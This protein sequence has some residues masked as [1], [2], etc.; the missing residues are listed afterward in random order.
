MPIVEYSDKDLLRDKLVEPAW[1]RVLIETIG[2]WTASSDQKSQNMVVEGTVLFNADNGSKEYAGVPIGG[3]GSWSFNS[4]AMGF[5]L[6]LTK[7]VARQLGIEP[8]Q[9]TPKMRFE[10]KH[11]E[12]KQ[13]D[14]FIVH[15]TY[16]GR[17][18]NKVDHQYREPRSLG[19]FV[20]PE[21]TT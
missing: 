19:D 18:R 8:D 5:S 3:L 2:E 12:G 7:S 14:V 21:A 11:L 15:N 1:Y 16:Q 17:T 10:Y 13:V 6:G 4:K 20:P 9:I